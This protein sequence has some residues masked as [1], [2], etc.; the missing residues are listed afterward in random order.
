MI[1][2]RR[3]MCFSVDVSLRTWLRNH[4]KDQNVTMSEWIRR[5][6]AESREQADSAAPPAESEPPARAA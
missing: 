6:I 1:E 3:Y 5:R 4:C 2:P